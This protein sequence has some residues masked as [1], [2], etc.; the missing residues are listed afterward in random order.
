MTAQAQLAEAIRA[1]PDDD[2]P[3]LVYADAIAATE[4]ERGEL[5]ALQCALAAGTL[6]R[7]AAIAARHRERELLAAHG[8]RW[9]DV[10]GLAAQV[11]FAR[12]FVDAAT[13]H[14]GVFVARGAEL[15]AR[16]PGLRRVDLATLVHPRSLVPD[17]GQSLPTTAI[18]LVGAVSEA[19]HLRAVRMLGV[20]AVF[21]RTVAGP[22]RELTP[23]VLGYLR[24]AGVLGVLQGLAIGQLDYRARVLPGYAVLGELAKLRDLELAR[25]EPH[26]VIALAEAGVAPRRFRA[27][28]AGP[29]FGLPA[30]ALGSL[31]RDADDLG[32]V[33]SVAGLTDAT[34]A[35]VRKL[36]V[37]A[38]DPALADAELPALQ[39]LELVDDASSP[40]P[41]RDAR[42]LAPLLAARGVRPRVLALRVRL[43]PGAIAAVAASPLGRALELI[44]IPPAFDHRDDGRGAD[45]DGMIADTVDAAPVV[46]P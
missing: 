17:D 1:A 31:A 10:G 11:S 5:I 24:R 29:E 16:A 45:F 42:W 46:L 34:R 44:A 18:P 25:L 33:D 38:G 7:D 8:A 22:T 35:R 27:A 23:V 36:A 9:A 26:D 12:G 30:A 6:A 3:R 14:A 21:V 20:P 4:P 2:E 37:L 39:E 19:P 32:V 41:L 15:L 28:L 13:V 43:A 40:R